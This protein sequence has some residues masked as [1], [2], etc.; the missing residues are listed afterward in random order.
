MKKL[1]KIIWTTI[2]LLGLP[3]VAL[4]VNITVPSA[5]SS[6][7]FLVSTTTGAYIS[8]TT[9][10][11]HF[12][13]I[14]GTSTATSTLNGPLLVGTS[15]QQ[16][17]GT[18][19]T[20]CPT[21]LT[22]S[23]NTSE[24][25]WSI[26]NVNSFFEYLMSNRNNGVSASTDFVTQNDLGSLNGSGYYLDLGINGSGYTSDIF[27]S[28]SSGY[29]YTSDS[30]LEIGTA[31]TT[32]NFP[33]VFFTNGTTLERM[34]IDY[35]G[36]IGVA[37]TS[38]FSLFSIH[39][40]N[41]ATNSILF[42]V[43]SST[44]SAT[45]TLVT[46]SNTGVLK[47]GRG[48]S[49]APSLAFADT[50][51]GISNGTSNTLSF[52]TSGGT[53]NWNGSTFSAS[54]GNSKDLGTTALIWRNLYVNAASTSLFSNFTT[55]YFGATA[56][57]TINSTGD[58]LVVGSTTLQNF[59][60]LNSTTTNAT[61]TTNA[62][63]NLVVSASS[64][65]ASTTVL[66]ITGGIGA[67][68]SLFSTFGIF[69][70]TTTTNSTTT[71]GY[72]STSA[73]STNFYT[74]IGT[75]AGSFLAVDPTGLIIATTSPTSGSGTVGNGEPGQFGFYSAHGTSIAGSFFGYASSTNQTTIFGAGAGGNNASTSAT[76]TGLTAFGN[77]AAAANTGANNTAVGEQTLL[78]NSAGTDNTA[79]G[80]NALWK[81]TGSFNTAVGS[82][83]VGGAGGTGSS[84]TGV[85]YASLNALTSGTGNTTLGRATGNNVTIGYSNTLVGYFAGLGL[86]TGSGNILIGDDAIAPAV[87]TNSFLNIGNL[88]FGTLPA[89]STT[90][91]VPASGTFSVGSTSPGAKFSIQSNNGDTNTSLFMIGSSTA[92][93]TSTLFS[94]NNIGST[95]LFQVPSQILLTDANSTVKGY[96]GTTCTNQFTRALSAL[97]VATCASVAVTDMAAIAANT[98]LA[99]NTSASAAPTALATSSLF[100]FSGG[101]NAGATTLQNV[102]YHSITYATS[103]A[104]TG[105]STYGIEV[106]YGETW[107]SVRCF[108]DVGTVNAQFGTY[109]ASTTL[110]NASTTI[111]TVS[112]TSNNT[113]T[114]GN[115]IYFAFGTPA[116]S[117]TKV[118]CTIKT[119]L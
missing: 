10:S 98:V 60:A 39:A 22:G 25:V 89:T 68:S 17:T 112:L 84:N 115:A 14:Y 9:D 94:I 74:N 88:L 12:G 31:S 29:L 30:P 72:F 44:A 47:L 53:V 82:N 59:T 24:A 86:T 35:T 73:S 96:T 78:T 13:S 16:C 52:N 79:V 118:T 70:N 101:F 41:G 26:G 43:G 32:G 37:S 21:L 108:T 51:A 65:L 33:M 5:P 46:I 85:G 34:R 106:G 7:Y 91:K 54:T 113:M 87:G 56:T 71:S 42:A 69:G 15:S 38:P 76:V 50:S 111:G 80:F 102:T 4:A 77:L 92:T 58:V 83:V 63:S 105:T 100:T 103:T 19:G 40:Q 48:T 45:T 2:A 6:G 109:A 104:W 95:T 11:A 36:N 81:I 75:A 49:A 28:K 97:G 66:N 116:S 90:L 107:N 110:F 1:N 62:S 114:A 18:T 99:N 57:T 119:T 20:G 27:P 8:T 23:K 67:F 93:A 61:T 55:A 64:T 117:P 3:L